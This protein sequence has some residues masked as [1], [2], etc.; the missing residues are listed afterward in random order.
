MDL[1]ALGVRIEIRS[2]VAPPIVLGGTGP[3]SN[4][5]GASGAAGDGASGGA[6]A[7]FKLPHVNVLRLLRPAVTVDVAGSRVVA[8]KGAGEPPAFPWVGVA[9]VAAVL[10]AGFLAGWGFG[11]RVR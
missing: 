1:S 3:G 4:A 7:L 10:G 9:V 11:R 2:A 5:G 8:W 6:P